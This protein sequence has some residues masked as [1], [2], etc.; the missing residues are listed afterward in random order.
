[1]TDRKQIGLFGGTF[2]PPTMAHLLAAEWVLDALNLAQVWWMPAWVNPLKQDRIVT[3][4][5][6]RL[7][8]LQES[9]AEYLQF[10]VRDDEILRK[11][12]S[13]TIDTLRSLQEQYPT[14]DF[15]LILGADSI[16]NFP[17]WK[18]YAEILQRVSITV[19]ARPGWN[20][21]D[22]AK[23]I[24]DKIRTV[25]FPP[26]PISSTLVRERVAA[27]KTVRFLVPDPARQIIKE[28]E[29]YR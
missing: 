25:E 22:I 8:M 10:V 16:A 2:D 9:L 6:L 13:Y 18:E 7:K 20:M 24:R 15:T 21:D 11:G 29:L 1:M 27:G 23:A 19:I 26:L 5:T 3:D 14:H 28:H 12:P 4:P 17:Q